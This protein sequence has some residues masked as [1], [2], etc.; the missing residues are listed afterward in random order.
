MKVFAIFLALCFAIATT[1]AGETQFEFLSRYTCQ[2]ERISSE[3]PYE[4]YSKAHPINNERNG[5]EIYS[6]SYTEKSYGFC[7]HNG[8]T[9]PKSFSCRKDS[10]G[11]FPLQGGT[12]VEIVEKIP[13]AIYQCTSGCSG[14]PKY[15]HDQSYE[16]SG[17]PDEENYE[18]ARWHSLYKSQLTE[19]A[20]KKK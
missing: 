1:H 9:T 18:S 7:K 16:P 14:L 10:H 3:L 11:R 8:E 2:Y 12:Y 13:N 17:E 19:C 15:I 6:Y 5:W 20:A 4:M